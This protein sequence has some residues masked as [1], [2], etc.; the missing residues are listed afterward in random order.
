MSLA[1]NLYPGARAP[2]LDETLFRAPP[3]AYRGTPF[4]SWNGP[5]GRAA[6]L[7]QIDALGRMGFGGFHIHARTGLATPYLG[8]AYLALMRACVRHGRR[9]GLLTWLYDEDRWPSGFGGGAVTRDPRHRM[10]YFLLTR[11]PYSGV[12]RPTPN[13]SAAQPG[14]EENG[15]LL[16]RYAVTLERGRLA[17]Y[18]RLAPGEPVPRDAAEWFLY[19]E[20]AGGTPWFNNQ[21]YVDTLSPAAIRRFVA[22]THEPLRAALGA[23]FGRAVPAIFTDEPQ[24]AIKGALSR[25]DADEDVAL[26]ATSDF[27]ASYRR[28]WGDDLLATFPEIVWELPGSRASATRYR[29]HEHVT[30]RFADAY[31]GTLARWCERHGLPLTGHMMEEQT[32]TSQTR[33][34]GEAMRSLAR[35]HL[36]GIDMLCDRFELNTAKQAQS[37]AHQFDR[38]GVLSELYGVTGWDYDFVGHKAQ[39]DWQAA[40]GVTTRAP[41]LAWVSMGGA[42][43]RDFPASIHYQS[44]WHR[45]YRLIEDH[46]ARTA[47]VLARG[48]PRVRV[49]VVHPIESF[50]LCFGPVAS[51]RREREARER[52]HAE[53]PEWL[54]GALIDFDYLSEYLLA[55]QPGAADAAGFTVGA[56]RYDAVV[57]PALRTIRGTTLARLERFAAA[58]GTVIFAGETPSLVDAQPSPRA[59]ELA[60]R[61]RRCAWDRARLLGLLEPFREI[62]CTDA[63]GARSDRLLHQLR[64]DGAERH[65]FLCHTD[66]R[67][68]L[69]GQQVRLRGAWRCFARDTFTGRKR[70]LFVRHA[71]GATLVPVDFAAHGHAL[72]TFRPGHPRV[73]Q[74]LPRAVWRDAGAIG[75]PLR[76]T[77]SEPNALLLDQPEW[78]WNDEA[79]RPREEILRIQR[80]LRERCALPLDAEQLAQPWTDRAPA[81][82]LG[83]VTLRFRVRSEVGVAAPQL[84]LEEPETWTIAWDGRPVANRARGW[85]V[86]EAIR[87]VPLPRLAPGEHEL[88]LTRDFTRRT[89]LEWCYLLGDFGVRLRGRDAR[90]TSPVRTL[91]FGDWTRQG[92]PFYA[93]NVTYELPLPVAGGTRARAVRFAKFSA[94][95]LRT[96]L[97]ARASVPV[98]FAPFRFEIGP[99]PAGAH[100]LRV[101]AYGNRHNAFGPLHFVDPSFPYTT[102][103]TWHSEGERWTYGYQLKPMGLLAAPRIETAARS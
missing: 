37:V 80:A 74:P 28:A 71:N 52:R 57:V 60:Q 76:V 27:L 47:V 84:A 18:T 78:R 50:W 87:R 43:K 15:A 94:P 51:T 85:W 48:R 100:C 91:R 31:A 8:R 17:R 56:M 102:P 97:D 93:G 59:R 64:V 83:R 2:R 103:D 69:D 4:W 7:R 3:A 24:H 42:A 62:D 35:F 45:E 77:L 12:R 90:L 29:Y 1:T 89:Q 98:A 21:T 9:R 33:S 40:L 66:R 19:L 75:A 11:T 5:L 6:L 36:P 70:E 67:H 72:L 92:L 81:P 96:Q 49:A 39:G 82:A 88:V 61:V 10:K 46:F 53:L 73:T 44:P 32:I 30:T 63:A 58:G 95:L 13:I 68:A 55:E 14:R 26:P 16:A 101:V 65:L 34:V 38:P 41:H 54:L 79:W 22:T 99:L 23:H 20:T 25:A 86:D